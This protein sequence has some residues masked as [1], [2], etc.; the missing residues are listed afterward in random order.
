MLDDA[1]FEKE[2]RPMCRHP[3]GCDDMGANEIGG[4]LGCVWGETLSERAARGDGCA[5]MG[6]SGLDDE[7]RVP[8][9][10]ELQESRRGC[11]G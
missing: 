8:V 11:L 4:E 9:K 2:Q 6:E 7:G 3:Q 10:G 1:L 5:E